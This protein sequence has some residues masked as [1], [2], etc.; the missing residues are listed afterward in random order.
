[1]RDWRLVLHLR[2]GLV[3]LVRRVHHCLLGRRQL[4]QHLL[5]LLMLRL[6]HVELLR[7][8]CCI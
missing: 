5:L 2:T 3:M 6:K 4:L 8:C 7:G 1:M